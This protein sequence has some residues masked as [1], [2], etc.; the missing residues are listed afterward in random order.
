MDVQLI[1][2]A[3]MAMAHDLIFNQLFPVPGT[4]REKLYNNLI[5]FGHF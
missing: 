1:D 5:L 4:H 3:K 2:V